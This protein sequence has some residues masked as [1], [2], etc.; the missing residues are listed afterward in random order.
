MNKVSVGETAVRIDLLRRPHAAV[1]EVRL[2][3]NRAP[4][5]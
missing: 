3:Q 2:Y 1:L 5:G 4:R